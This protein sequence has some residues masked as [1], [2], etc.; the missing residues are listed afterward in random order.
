MNFIGHF[1]FRWVIPINFTVL[2]SFK[3]IRVALIFIMVLSCGNSVNANDSTLTHLLLKRLELLQSKSDLVF[4]KGSFSSYRAYSLNKTI[5]KADDNAFFTGLISFTLKNLL[6]DLNSED[7]KIAFSIIERSIPFFNHFKNQKGRNT[8][9][10]WSTNPPKIFPNSGWMNLFDHSQSLPDDLDDT[11]ILLMAM[12]APD[13]IASEVHLLM[14]GFANGK[15]KEIRNTFEAYKNI[16]AYSTWFGKKMPVDFDISV[17]TNVLSFVQH[18]QLKWT[19]F[20]SAS[21]Q[22]IVKVIADKNYL[23]APS[24]VSP[25]Y[26]RTPIILYHLSRLM[27]IQAIPE[28]ENHKTELIETTKKLLNESTSFIDRTILSTSLMRWGIKPPIFTISTGKSLFDMIDDP[29]F[30][31]FIANMS[32]MLPNKWKDLAGTIGVGKF[33]YYCEAYNTCLLLENMVWQKRIQT[34]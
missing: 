3:N 4:S 20:D 27:S 31:F 13:S 18:Y 29:N 24:S 17:L 10:F 5:E 23:N 30:V 33:S 15:G 2:T 11:V 34:H 21:L 9:N 25:H 1:A 22:L 6:K 8:Y 16:P 26:N 32:S 12:D 14:Q 28:L 7:Q 19:S